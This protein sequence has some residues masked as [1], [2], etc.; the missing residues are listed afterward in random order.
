MMPD[1]IVQ[2]IRECQ[3]AELDFQIAHQSMMDA[4]KPEEARIALAALRVAEKRRRACRIALIFH[5][6]DHR[7]A[8][9]SV[10]A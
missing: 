8:A 9:I 3:N 4:I 10:S 1:E 6:M 5:E 7:C 2:N